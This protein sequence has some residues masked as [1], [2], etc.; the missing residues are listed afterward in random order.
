VSK[1][2]RIDQKGRLKIPAHLVASLTS[3]GTSFFITSEDCQSVRIYPSLIWAEVERRLV[4]LSIR[5]RAKQRLLLRAK[6][7]GQ[8]V[9]MDEHARLLIPVILRKAADIEGEVDVLD[10]KTYLEVWNHSRFL[11]TLDLAPEGG[12][13]E[14]FFH[15]MAS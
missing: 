1:P 3:L 10:Y 8:A 2:L 6:Y 15:R 14:T 7:F 12:E 11:K 13:G 9:Q 5:S 4:R